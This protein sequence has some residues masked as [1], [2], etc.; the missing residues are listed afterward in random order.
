MSW[1]WWTNR[2]K[3]PIEMEAFD[4]A[5][6]QALGDFKAS[7]QAWSDAAYSRPRTVRETVVRRSWRLA[8]GWSVASML[9]TGTLSVGLYEHH[10]TQVLAEFAAQRAAEEQRQLA[11]ERAQELAR[12][13]EDMLASVDTDV[14]REVPSPMEPLA[15]LNDGSEAH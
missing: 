1:K 11:A 6:K 3:E 2:A 15:Q 10:H 5:L 13:E 7:V 14:S 4:P 9:I 12:Q 8:A